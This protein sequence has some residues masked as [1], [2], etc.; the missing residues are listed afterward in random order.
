MDTSF[1]HIEN[2][3]K[4]CASRNEIFPYQEMLLTRLLMHTQNKLLENNKNI[5]DLKINDTLFMALI[6]IESHENNRIQ[7][8]E[9]SS[10]LGVSRT[11]VTRLAD[12][13]EKYG[14]VTRYESNNDRRCLYLQ[15]TEKGLDLLRELLPNQHRNLHQLWSIL[16][17]EEK[18]QLELIIR[19]LLSRIDWMNGVE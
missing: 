9:L 16:N 7:P 5:N 11:N 4:F 6:T 18:E 3:L 10:A 17:N 15:L 13:M 19:K 1:T 14:W 2:M 12:K 8:S